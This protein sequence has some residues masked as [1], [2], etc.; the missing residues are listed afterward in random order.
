LLWFKLNRR[1]SVRVCGSTPIPPT[2]VPAQEY[3]DG[4]FCYRNRCHHH[5]MPP[6]AVLIVYCGLALPLPMVCRR[7]R[8]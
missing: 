1:H 4:V 2:L 6:I 8:Y 5:A 3:A 7:L